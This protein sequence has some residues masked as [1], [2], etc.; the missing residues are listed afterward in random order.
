[1][2]EKTRLPARVES[3]V[4]FIDKDSAQ[5]PVVGPGKQLVF[6]QEELFGTN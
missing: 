2:H 4:R 3:K 5:K 1:V 6:Q